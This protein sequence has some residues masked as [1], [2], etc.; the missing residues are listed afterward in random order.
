MA[1][2]PRQAGGSGGCLPTGGAPDRVWLGCPSALL[3]GVEGGQVG[4]VG[5]GSG[6]VRLTAVKRAAGDGEEAFFRHDWLVREWI[7][8]RDKLPA[9]DGGKRSD[10][11]GGLHGAGQA[12]QD[13]VRPAQ[14]VLSIGRQRQPE[15]GGL[16]SLQLFGCVG[17]VCVGQFVVHVMGSDWIRGSPPR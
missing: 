4:Q 2:K 6:T 8:C 7:N 10:Q 5:A 16:Q 3:P 11:V 12:D 13:S 1:G 17:S 9:G 14:R 15:L